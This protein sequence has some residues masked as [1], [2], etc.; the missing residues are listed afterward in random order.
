M[1]KLEGLFQ[2]TKEKPDK[3]AFTVQEKKT[4]NTLLAQPLV[5]FTNGFNRAG[6]R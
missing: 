1:V 4:V 2:T 3:K 6:D 5:P